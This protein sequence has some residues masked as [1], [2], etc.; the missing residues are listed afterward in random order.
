MPAFLVVD[1]SM[2][3]E[4]AMNDYERHAMEIMARHG[5]RPIAYDPQPLLVEGVWNDRLII[6]E[7]PDKQHVLNYVNDPDYQHW[8]MVRHQNARTRSA[9]AAG[10]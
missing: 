2:L 3:N 5:G 8:K 6:L 7:F 4:T 9:V 1:I 10:L